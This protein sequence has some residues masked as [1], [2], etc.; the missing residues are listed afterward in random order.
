MVIDNTCRA[1]EFFR[2]MFWQCI[3][4][5]HNNATEYRRRLRDQRT[6]QKYYLFT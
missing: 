1:L 3:S 6:S 5:S 4:M 2:S